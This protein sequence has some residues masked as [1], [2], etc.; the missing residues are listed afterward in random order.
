MALGTP[1]PIQP[2]TRRRAFEILSKLAA[3][4]LALTILIGL[5]GHLTRDRSVGLAVCM[6]VPVLPLG[7]VAIMLDLARTGRALPRGR[8]ILTALAVGASTLA[9]IPMI[10]RGTVDHSGENAPEVSLLHWNVQWGGAFRSPKTWAAQRAEILS[11]EP[12]LIVLS[13]GPTSDWIDQLVADLG[14]GAAWVGEG[15]GPPNRYWF[16]LAVC[17]RWPVR[18]DKHIPLPNGAAISVIAEVRGWPM[19]LLVVDGQSN[20]F[21]SRLPFLR[22]IADECQRAAAEGHSYDA[23]VGDFNTP[24]R[25]IGF[26]ALAAQGFQ[27]A[28]R[29]TRGWRGTFPSFMPVYDIDHVWLGPATQV[30][31]CTLFNGPS[32]D[33]RGQLVRLQTARRPGS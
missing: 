13:E 29:S 32:T 25:S 33:H 26:D 17:S 16:K 18:L 28:S 5:L 31:S 2:S 15:Q 10:G 22:A 11:H 19:R 27:L 8:F 14:V 9:A 3:L 12:D 30:K 7:L 6:Y 1:D 21:H 20:P 24:S 4:G 23:I